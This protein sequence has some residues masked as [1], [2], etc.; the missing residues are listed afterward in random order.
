MNAWTTLETSLNKPDLWT[1]VSGSDQIIDE[2]L[3]NHSCILPLFV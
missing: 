1:F 2:S 3:E